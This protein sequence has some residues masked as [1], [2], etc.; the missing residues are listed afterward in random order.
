VETSLH[1][2]PDSFE[3]LYREHGERIYRFCHRL[4]RHRADAEDLTQEV[5]ILAYRGLAGFDAR[6]SLATWLYRIAYR[7][8]QRFR[9]SG[10]VDT[11]ALDEGLD[12]P[13]PDL[14]AARLDRIALDDA[15][16]Q[17]SEPLREAFILVKAEG[18]KYREAAEVLGVPQGT[19]QSRVHA[20][21][22]ELRALLDPNRG[23][24][25][26]RRPARTRPACLKEAVD[27][28]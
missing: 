11:V 10:S 6:S 22:T 25:W 23:E 28:L 3:A 5:F 15:L 17:L 13:S 19:V 14:S 20:A 21:V 16:A 2:R 12:A 7:R 8:W 4:C 1:R 18:L 26:P 27:E 24:I 9:S